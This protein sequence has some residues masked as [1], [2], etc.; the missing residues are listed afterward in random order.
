MTAADVKKQIVNEL[1][2]LPQKFIFEVYDFIEFLKLREDKWFLD[3][4]N[5]RT[6][7]ALAAKKRGLK[8]SSLKELQKEIR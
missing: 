8:F 3:F 2:S 4:V 1:N 7:A 5:K 6:G